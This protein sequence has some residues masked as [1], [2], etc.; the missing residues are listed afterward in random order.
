M[1]RLVARH[2]LVEQRREHDA[3]LFGSGSDARRAAID[4]QPMKPINNNWS[5][6]LRKSKVNMPMLTIVATTSHLRRVNTSI[7]TYHEVMIF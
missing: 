3:W 1:Q 4:A 7:G 6:P 5:S 2:R